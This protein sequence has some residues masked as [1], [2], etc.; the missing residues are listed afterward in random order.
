MIEKKNASHYIWGDGCDGWHLLQADVLSVIEERMPPNRS[1]VR[2][3]HE[4]SRQ[5]F[6]VLAG[7]LSLDIEGKEFDLLPRQGVEVAPGIAHRAFNRS[8]ADAE[9]LVISS[10]PSHGD[11]ISDGK[12]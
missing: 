12:S 8:T 1:E 6:Y 9:F 11:R 2:H 4:K 3:F 7:M 5:F 10:P